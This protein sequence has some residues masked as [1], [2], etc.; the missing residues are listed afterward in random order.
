MARGSLGQKPEADA[1][2]QSPRAVSGVASLLESGLCVSCLPFWTPLSGLR[3]LQLQ[4]QWAKASEFEH[5]TCVIS[6]EES[7]ASWRSRSLA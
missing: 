7:D 2:L 6:M 3:H 4:G 1:H 5:E